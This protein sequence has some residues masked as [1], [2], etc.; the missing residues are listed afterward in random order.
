MKRLAFGFIGLLILLIV[1]FFALNNFI[2]QQKQASNDL[3]DVK[4]VFASDGIVFECG[5]RGD[6][7]LRQSAASHQVVELTVEG[8]AYVLENVVAASGARYLGGE[9]EFWEQGN[10]ATLRV[11]AETFPPC[12]QRSEEGVH[13]RALALHNWQLIEATEAGDTVTLETEAF[14]LSFDTA[15]KVHLV[16]DCNNHGG[17]YR[18]VAGVLTF[19]DLISTKMYCEGSVEDRY[20]ELI[21]AVT[22]YAV[23][24][25]GT[26]VLRGNEVQ[27]VY[28]PV[29]NP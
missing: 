8:N 20:I 22:E 11:G 28:A 19:G 7:V 27:L 15:G 17:D 25:D 26:L 16:T 5:E 21:S 24:E 9:V 10:T 14:L 23:S 29:R 13:D 12:M 3:P 18:A 4:P 6:V 1:G 2:Y